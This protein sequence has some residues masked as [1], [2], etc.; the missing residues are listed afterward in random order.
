MAADYGKVAAGAVVAAIG[1]APRG[2]ARLV[3]RW[4]GLLRCLEHRGIGERDLRRRVVALGREAERGATSTGHAAA[5]VDEGIEHQ[6]KELIGELE[7]RL[8]ATGGGFAGKLVQGAGQIVA[9]EAEQRHEG[10][11]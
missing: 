4:Q 8:L 3:D 1:A 7:R 2:P 10:R 5:A 11:W 6:P 9:G